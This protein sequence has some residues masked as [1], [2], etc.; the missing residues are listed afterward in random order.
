MKVLAALAASATVAM[1]V[2]HAGSGNMVRLTSACT[3]PHTN[4]KKLAGDGLCSALLLRP[5]DASGAGAGA[6]AEAAGL[7]KKGCMAGVPRRQPKPPALRGGAL[8]TRSIG[9]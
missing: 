4:A 2:P 1:A 7:G 8:A 5:F 3:Y 9:F 6:G